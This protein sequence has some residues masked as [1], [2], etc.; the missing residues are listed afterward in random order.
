[1][2]VSALINDALA[3]AGIPYTKVETQAAASW[4]AWEYLTQAAEGAGSLDQEAM[5]DWLLE[6]G[7]DTLFQGHIE[8]RPDEQNYFED[9]SKLKQIQDGDWW[10]VYPEEFAAPDRSLIYSPDE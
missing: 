2:E 4:T 6:N 7:A 1:V 5:C 8:F 9:L 10:V 3:E